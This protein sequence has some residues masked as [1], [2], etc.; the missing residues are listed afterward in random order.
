VLSDV[1][2]VRHGEPNRNTSIPYRSPPG[3]GL[4]E[5]GR[6][7]ARRAATF[8]ADKQIEH[9]F[10]SPYTRAME[11][12][13]ALVTQLGLSLSTVPLIAEYRLDETEAQLQARLA[14]FVS[15][16]MAAPYARVAVVS[17]AAPIGE[18]LLE[19]TQQPREWLT[20]DEVGHPLPT[21]GI[22]HAWRAGDAWQAELVFQPQHAG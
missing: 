10:V 21:G 7:E 22:W 11:T 20:V 9:L 16:L 13:E 2:L 12:A 14:Q 8:L 1:F 5:Q 3:P 17:H 19:L 18:L 4:C 6:D 15:E